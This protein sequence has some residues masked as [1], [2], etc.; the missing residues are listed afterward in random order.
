MDSLIAVPHSE[1]LQILKDELFGKI[2]KFSLVDD[3]NVVYYSGDI[4]SVFFDG[5]GVLTATL[6][7]P[8][9]DHFTHWNKWVRVISDDN[10]IIANVETPSIQ[11]VKGVG[12]EQIIKL[13]VSGEA[14]N[15]IF[16]S[17]DYLTDAELENWALGFSKRELKR[18]DFKNMRRGRIL[19]IIANP[20]TGNELLHYPLV[21]LQS[22]ED[23]GFNQIF[24]R[25]RKT[26]HVPTSESIYRLDNYY[27]N[28]TLTLV[29]EG[30][31]NILSLEDKGEISEIASGT[32]TINQWILGADLGEYSGYN[33]E[34]DFVVSCSVFDHRNPM[35][36]GMRGSELLSNLELD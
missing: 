14:G 18:F 3:Q 27:N 20:Q 16:K 25:I 12:G 33:I 24:I 8:K 36:D 17:D 22:Q 23:W 19:S 11:F 5:N 9:E 2:K 28:C 7:V 4:H 6:L 31:C 26:Y 21:K 29:Q 1:G 32:R 30:G 15:V 13:T 35:T 10:K 34:L